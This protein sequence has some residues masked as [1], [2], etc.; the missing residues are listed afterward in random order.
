[1]RESIANGAGSSSPHY[2][3]NDKLFFLIEKNQVLV[4][5]Y[6]SHQQYLLDL[7]YFQELL[8]IADTH[9]SNNS[10]ILKELLEAG[11]VS[12][13]PFPQEEW[14]W[15]ALSKIYHIGCQS[16]YSNE[17]SLNKD[18]LSQS[19]LEFC[20][21]IAE[22][23]VEL[24]TEK[25]GQR[26][27]LPQ[28]DLSS[29][30]KPYWEVLK[31]RKTCR[32]FYSESISLQQLSTA[33]FASFGLIHGEWEELKQHDLKLTGMRKASPASGGLH[34]EEA[35]VVVFRVEGLAPGL[36][37]YRPQDH[38]LSLLKAGQFEK[39]VIELNMGQFFSE[40]M[41][42]GVYI[43]ARFDKIWWKYKHS[44]AY[45]VT[46]VDIG[47]LS[48]TFLLT[49]TALGLDTWV[50][51]AFKDDKLQSFLGMEGNKEAALLFVGA[52]KGSGQAIPNEMLG[53]V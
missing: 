9:V 40:G 7:S 45:R 26:V 15:D 33:L 34:S 20:Q 41:A 25:Q 30:Q 21:E 37:H 16:V 14:G 4:W 48:Q 32:A 29:L 31:Q 3:I 5:D 17:G 28:P 39:E 22:K 1:M 12:D 44:R 51:A 52:G 42:F 53:L 47:H 24:Y 2:H 8:N 6:A 27:E 46:L 13:I 23:P 10:A 49:A 36:Y 19:Y 18:E 38:Q 35:Y 43:S 50:T 11:L